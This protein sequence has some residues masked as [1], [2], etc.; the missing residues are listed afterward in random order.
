MKIGFTGSRHGLTG[1]QRHTLWRL[2]SEWLADPAEAHH[3]DCLGADAAFHDLI[4]ELWP[5]CHVCVHP[6]AN[7][8]LRAYKHGDFVMT[9]KPYLERDRAIVEAVTVLIACPSTDAPARHSGT[10]YT[11]NYAKQ[12]DWPRILI[13]PNGFALAIGCASVD[14][15]I[16]GKPAF[17]DGGGT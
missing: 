17:Q 14:G 3:G 9:P 15:T 16:L 6:P 10:W 7:T 13:R 5:S 4:R 1:P 11:Y 12:R 2:L 8:S